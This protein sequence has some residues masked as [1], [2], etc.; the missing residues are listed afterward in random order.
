MSNKRACSCCGK[1]FASEAAF[2]AHL[3]LNYRCKTPEQMIQS[4]LIQVGAGW[5]LKKH[6]KK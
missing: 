5:A 3:G 2:E 6:V 1:S 4:G